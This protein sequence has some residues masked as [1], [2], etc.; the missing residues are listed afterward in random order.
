MI[1]AGQQI[2]GY[3]V[4]HLLGRGGMGEVYLAQHRRVARRAAI[5]VLIPELSQNAIVLERFFN[6]ARAASLIRHPGIVEILDCD[7]YL[8]QAYI[9]MEY[10]DGESF[11]GYLYRTGLEQDIPFLLGVGVA[12]A[13]A[14]GAAHATGIIHR[15]LKPDNIYLHLGFGTDANVA[16][17]ILDFGIAKLAQQDGGPSQTSTGVLLGTP[18]YMSPEQC[19]GAGR[20]DSRSDIYSLGCIFYEA[21]CG[22]PPFVRDGMGDLII[23]HVSETPEAPLA[24]VPTTPPA[25]NEL[26]MRMLAKGT[27]ERPQTMDQVVAEL[28]ACARDLGVNLDAPLRP[29]LPVERPAVTIESALTQVP[30]VGSSGIE[31]T[32]LGPRGRPPSDE[33]VPAAATPG[34]SGNVAPRELSSPAPLP[35]LSG[36]V[37]QETAPRKT[38][39]LSSTASEVMAGRAPAKRSGRWAALAVGAAAVLGGGIVLLRPHPAPTVVAPVPS[40]PRPAPTVPPVSPE[41]KTPEPKK[42]VAPPPEERPPPADPESVHIDFQGIPAGTTAQLDGKRTTFPIKLARGPDVH[43]IVLRPPGQSSRTI[44]LDGTRDRIVDFVAIAKTPS[45]GGHTVTPGSTHGGSRKSEKGPGANSGDREA[46]TDI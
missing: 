22:G 44:E 3:T 4:L 41:P 11:G 30:P 42:E 17:K 28:R 12:V 43:R 5:K 25:L 24:R 31:T 40:E 35:G 29:R 6:E 21:I 1:G 34:R 13:G 19:R 45:V 15:D 39:T 37:R 7:L 2:G 32:P 10:L 27:D 16:V 46:I 20:V 33:G 18:A 14:V 26:I 8:G 9:V 38:T 23:A 36:P